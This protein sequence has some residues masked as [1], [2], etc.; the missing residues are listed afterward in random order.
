MDN[1]QIFAGTKMIYYMNHPVLKL[2][3]ITKKAVKGLKS[4]IDFL[5]SYLD[6]TANMTTCKMID[7]AL[8]LVKT[9]EGIN[10]IKY[11]LFNG[12]RIQRGYAALYFKRN[13]NIM[14]LREAVSKQCI[15]EKQAFA[16]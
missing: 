16:K 3:D 15:D 14:I 7:F 4:D 1:I 2:N 12:T 11:Y 13:G 6:E 9:D 5:M 10:Q 8:S